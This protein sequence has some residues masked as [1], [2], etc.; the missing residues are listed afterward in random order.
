[1]ECVC[2]DSGV[3]L[4]SAPDV[5]TRSLGT[6]FTENEIFGYAGFW[7]PQRCL[8]CRRCGRLWAGLLAAGPLPGQ[9]A[10]GRGLLRTCSSRDGGS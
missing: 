8:Q 2:P 7:R 6:A 5:C 9:T 3:V 1:M 4:E 10:V